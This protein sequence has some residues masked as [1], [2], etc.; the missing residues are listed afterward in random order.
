MKSKKKERS[1]ANVTTRKCVLIALELKE[2]ADKEEYT[3]VQEVCFER[4][5]LHDKR[6][7]GKTYFE[8]RHVM[9]MFLESVLMHF[10]QC[11]IM[12]QFESGRECCTW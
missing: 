2:S 11:C 5:Y 1:G 4:Y 7:N 9:S 3:R 12:L 6:W 8:Y 10:L